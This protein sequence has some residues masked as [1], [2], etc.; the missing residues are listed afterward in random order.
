MVERKEIIFKP[1]IFSAQHKLILDNEFIEF[2]KSPED[3][4]PI[5]FNRLEIDAIRYGVV[6]SK[7]YFGMTFLLVIKSFE[8]KTIK[9]HLRSA[10]SIRNKELR[11]KYNLVLNTVISYYLSDTIYQY[12]KMLDDKTSFSMLNIHFSEHGITLRKEYEIKWQ[13]LGFKI[14]G[15]YLT[16]FLKSK[17]EINK[18][19]D[20][21]YDWNTV[22]VYN[23]IRSA[24]KAKGLLNK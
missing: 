11:T 16:M 8:G 12:C 22:V 23:V 24:L 20:F 4:D 10:Y 9:F 14:Y 13:D 2:Y 6:G 18:T 19:L 5:R 15:R 17:P 1:T 21:V 7:F 3:K